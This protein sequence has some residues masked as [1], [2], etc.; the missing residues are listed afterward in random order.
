MST[1]LPTRQAHQLR[2][3]HLVGDLLTLELRNGHRFSQTDAAGTRVE[4]KETKFVIAQ[5]TLGVSENYVVVENIPL[6][7]SLRQGEQE[8]PLDFSPQRQQ[9]RLLRNG[10]RA[11]EGTVEPLAIFVFPEHP[12]SCG[13]SWEASLTLNIVDGDPFKASLRCTVSDLDAEGNVRV[14]MVS[15]EISVTSEGRT[16]QVGVSGRI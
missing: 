12:L 14:A 3:G 11:D 16:I 4:E 8:G 5:T 13:D 2:Y 9:L 7:A 10:A 6:S 1:L 15:P